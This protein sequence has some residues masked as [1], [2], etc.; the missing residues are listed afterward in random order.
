[1]LVCI[2]RS[3]RKPKRSLDL[4]RAGWTKITEVFRRRRFDDFRIFFGEIA[5]AKARNR[6]VVSSVF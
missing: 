6:C 4:T 3:L 1:M 5:L 2:C